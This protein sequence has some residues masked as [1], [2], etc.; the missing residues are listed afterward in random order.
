MLVGTRMKLNSKSATGFL[1][2]I[3]NNSVIGQQLNINLVGNFQISTLVKSF[4][5]CV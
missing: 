4:S 1:L 5:F 3:V 2:C